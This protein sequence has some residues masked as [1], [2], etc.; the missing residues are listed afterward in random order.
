MSR[1]IPDHAVVVVWRKTERSSKRYM[2]VYTNATIDQVNTTRKRN[3]EPT[4]AE[5]V[6]D[7]LGVGKSFIEEYKSKYKIKG[8]YLWPKQ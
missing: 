2:T 4:G 8:H 3:P 1:E 5:G 7:A 6:W